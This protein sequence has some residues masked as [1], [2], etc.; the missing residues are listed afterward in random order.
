VKIGGKLYE[1]IAVERTLSARSTIHAG[2]T[3]RLLMKSF[4]VGPYC[5]SPYLKNATNKG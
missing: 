4:L 1:C 3:I 5:R 2:E